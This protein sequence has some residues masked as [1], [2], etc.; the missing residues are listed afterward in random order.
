MIQEEEQELVVIVEE[1]QELLVV[2]E[3][4]DQALLAVIK[5]LEERDQELPHETGGRSLRER[6]WE[7]RNLLKKKQ[8]WDRYERSVRVGPGA[9]CRISFMRVINF[10]KR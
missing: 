10:N 1:D 9:K 4:L 8:S 3:E 6:I 5:V 7:G 2:I